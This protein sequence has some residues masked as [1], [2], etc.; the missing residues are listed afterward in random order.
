MDGDPNINTWQGTASGS[1]VVE[2]VG[3]P[4]VGKST[5]SRRTA[6]VLA[7]DQPR[8]SEP[9]GKINDRSGPLRILSKGHF[10]LEHAIRQPRSTIDTARR[11]KTMGQ[12][13]TA[14]LVRV[15]FNF[16]YV[17]GVVAHAQSR[18][19]VTLLDQGPYQ[20]LWS[21]GLRSLRDWDD[22]LDRLDDSLSRTAPDLVVFVEVDI[23]TIT[24]RLQTRTDGDTRFAPG[25]PE[26]DRGIDGYDYLKERIQSADHIDS[27]VI[28]NETRD[29]LNTAPSQIADAINEI[30]N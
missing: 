8:V 20:G 14:D 30:Q 24:D 23:D 3:L 19:G 15:S 28:K 6:A 9:I 10:A 25:I 12:P 2:F 18:P 1:S 4:G 11:I 22:L 7:K 16:Q 5:L 17:T 13:T 26:F 27:L 29:D 21:I